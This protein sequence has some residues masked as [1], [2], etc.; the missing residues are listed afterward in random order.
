MPAYLVL[1]L[2]APLMSFGGVCVD[3]TNPTDFFPGLS[4]LTGL[5]G[6]ALGLDHS[7]TQAL[8]DLQEHLEFAVRVDLEGTRMVDYQSV[9]LGQ[10]FMRGGWTTWG[11]EERRGGAKSAAEGTHQ[12]WRHYWVDRVVTVMLGLRPSAMSSLDQIR[13]ALRS[14]A[15]TLW[16]GRKCC[17]PSAPIFHDSIEAESLLAALET[18][19]LS[20]RALSKRLR[21][22]WPEQDDKRDS[23]QLVYVTDERDWANQIHV[24][25]RR[26]FEGAI[27]VPTVGEGNTL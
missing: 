20:P 7:D 13:E 11:Q 18:Y 25:R 23:A 3:E 6:N 22:R 8:R 27:D 24:G 10:E 2:E 12:R 9:A 5:I 26:L 16:I 14:P 1:R 21:A 4:L 15:R 17:L 19:P